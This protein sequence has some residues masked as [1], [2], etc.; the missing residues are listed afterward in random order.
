ME[1]EQVSGFV[2]YNLNKKISINK[3]FWAGWHSL[4]LPALGVLVFRKKINIKNKKK[5]G[6]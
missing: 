4:S 6:I 1:K 3:L 5:K 2:S